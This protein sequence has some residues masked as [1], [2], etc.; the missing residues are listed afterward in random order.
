MN[1]NPY[2]SVVVPVR[3]G[4]DYINRCL[5]ALKDSTYENFEII[6]V[7]DASSDNTVEISQKT[8]A[9]II[10]LDKQSGPA[11]ARNR[12][13]GSARG[14]IVLFIDADVVITPDTIGLIA[15]AFTENPDTSAVFG[16][17]DDTPAAPDF[18]SQYRN[19]L[20]HY[21]HQ[22]AKRDA[23]TFW[24]GCGAIRKAVFDELGGFDE[25]RHP[26]P[27]ME[28]IEIGL[29]MSEKGY[30]IILDKNIQVKHLKHW[31]LYS[32]I[33]TDISQRAVP[34]SQLIL[35]RK[36]VPRD[37]NLRFRD[38]FSTALVGLII[39]A[40]FFYLLGLF[41]QTEIIANNYLLLTAII[42]FTAILIL[43]R[44]LYLFFL[45]KRGVGFAFLSIF[46]HIL[47]YIYSGTT[48]GILWIRS[49]IQL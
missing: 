38:R 41:T 44:D 8:G 7:D 13:A 22:R 18:I 28:D 1:K 19:L 2:I 16:S 36:L 39:I 21:V 49:K 5:L 46:M 17:Y 10:T 42:S 48:F 43:N 23:K 4:S 11:A 26:V 40:V 32:L 37:L 12:G 25:I 27:S 9:K 30:K 34:W 24:T 35:E 33:K 29:R 47:F 14:D 15:K 6:V 20:H 45:K 31:G 3:N